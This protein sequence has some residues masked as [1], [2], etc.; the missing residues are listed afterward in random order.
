MPSGVALVTRWP[1]R[2][3]WSA[4]RIASVPAPWRS[5]SCCA[6]PPTSATPEEQ[7][8]RGGVLVAQAARLVLGAV[9]DALGARVEA[10]LAALDPGAPG[11]DRGE[12]ATERGEVHAQA[13]QRLGG[14]P[15]VGVHERGEQVLRVEHGALHPLGELLGG[16]D[17]LLGLLGE[18]VELHGSCSRVRRVRFWV[19]R[20][21][22]RGSG[23]S[24]RSRN[25]FAASSRR[26]VEAG[27]QHDADLRR[28][29]R[30]VPPSLIRA[31]PGR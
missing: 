11:Q 28:T 5:R 3:V 4:P 10:Q 15:V 14:D 17:G 20:W 18:A 21:C 29:G 9:D 27:G 16:D 26:L 19:I 1:P 12:L 13:A 2:T 23:W 25:A 7:V 22:A 31:C 6:S 8:L 24:T 30:R